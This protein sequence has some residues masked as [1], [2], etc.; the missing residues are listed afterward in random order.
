M[1]SRINSRSS[2]EAPEI[3]RYGYLSSKV[4]QS[5]QFTQ[6]NK[7]TQTLNTKQKPLHVLFQGQSTSLN[8]STNKSIRLHL[9]SQYQP[10][11]K[12]ERNQ[13]LLQHLVSQSNNSRLNHSLQDPN[14]SSISNLFSLCQEDSGQLRSLWRLTNCLQSFSHHLRIHLIQHL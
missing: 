6:L 9:R 11:N 14:Q 8:Q 13:S 2:L 5:N 3:D 7:L 1:D 10:N 12:Q 4:H